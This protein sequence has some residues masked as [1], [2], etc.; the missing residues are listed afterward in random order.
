MERQPGQVQTALPPQL[1]GGEAAGLSAFAEGS[2]G[3]G[4]AAGVPAARH[5]LAE[6]RRASARTGICLENGPRLSD[7]ARFSGGSRGRRGGAPVASFDRDAP[8]VE[9]IFPPGGVENADRFRTARRIRS[10]GRHG[11]EGCALGI[12][13]ADGGAASPRRPA[14]A[15]AAGWRGGE[16]LFVDLAPVPGCGYGPGAGRCGVFSARRVCRRARISALQ[17]RGEWI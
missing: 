9:R 11:R 3:G 1:R 8:P 12:V 10:A 5:R 13:G 16:H 6:S 15:G 14:P 2:G 17:N 4:S 7:A